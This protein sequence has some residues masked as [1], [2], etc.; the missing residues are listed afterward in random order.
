[1]DGTSPPVARSRLAVILRSVELVAAARV[2][3]T[4]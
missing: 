3:E 2:L 4:A 1:M